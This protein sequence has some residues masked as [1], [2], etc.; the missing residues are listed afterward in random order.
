[1]ADPGAPAWPVAPAEQVARSNV[2]AVFDPLLPRAAEQF[3]RS[4]APQA[5]D[6]AVEAIAEF[7][8]DGRWPGLMAALARRAATMPR[9]MLAL[10]CEPP[11]VAS[12]G[13][14]PECRGSDGSRLRINPATGQI[15]GMRLAGGLPH[16]AFAAG[17][18]P[19]LRLAGGDWLERVDM[20]G[21]KGGAGTLHLV[22]RH[23]SGALAAA[24]HGLAGRPPWQALLDGRPLP[25][26]ALLNA[27]LTE[28]GEGP[29][30]T[31]GVGGPLP[32]LEMPVGVP[33]AEARGAAPALAAFQAWC[34]ACHWSAETFPP[35]FLQGPAE[36]LEN[37]LRQCAP[38][39][40][41]RLA[42]ARQPRAQRAKTPMPPETLLPAFGTHAE[43]WAQGADRAALEETIR[44][45]LV[46]ESGREPD[47]PT[48]LAGGYEALRPC[49]APAH[50]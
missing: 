10:N 49:L 23:D 12:A 42:M 28:L 37:R 47:L 27:L 15:E 6:E 8:V 45:M 18:A 9:V 13:A 35:N 48:L 46:A 25:R 14:G 19:A 16:P 17:P 4:D 31:A 1:S 39:I 50:P 26:E 38:R 2:A 30:P 36:T 21:L 33:A 29:P 20:S 24:L 3:W 32:Q 7:V 5:V 44:R 11:A 43:A 22:L 41:V 40:Y 34:A